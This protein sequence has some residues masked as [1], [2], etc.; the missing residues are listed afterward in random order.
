MHTVVRRCSK[1]ALL[2]TANI[3]FLAGDFLLASPS[4]CFQA[5]CQNRVGVVV[6][7]VEWVGVHRAQV[8]YLQLDECGSKFLGIAELEREGVCRRFVSI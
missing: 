5:L 8:L 6:G 3:D 2:P 1:L 4:Y 7:G